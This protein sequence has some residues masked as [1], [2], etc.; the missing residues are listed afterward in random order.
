MQTIEASELIVRAR[1]TEKLQ[2]HKVLTSQYLVYLS[3]L[4]GRDFNYLLTSPVLP[5]LLQ[6]YESVTFDFADPELDRDLARPVGTD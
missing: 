5:P 1:F 3:L 2:T 6:D 4:W